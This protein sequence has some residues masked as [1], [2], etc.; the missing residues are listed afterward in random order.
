MATYKGDKLLVEVTDGGRY[1]PCAYLY[2]IVNEDVHRA[3]ME[4]VASAGG[5]EPQ[6]EYCRDDNVLLNDVSEIV[7]ARH[8]HAL[9]EGWD[10]RFFLDGWEACSY[11]GYDCGDTIDYREILQAAKA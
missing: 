1:A 9:E 7:P 8:L 10:A 5:H 11:Y 6:D 3:C 4:Q 2:R